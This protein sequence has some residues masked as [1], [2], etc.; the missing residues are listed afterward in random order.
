MLVAPFVGSIVDNINSVQVDSV[1]VDFQVREVLGS[2]YLG[3]KFYL[4]RCKYEIGDTGA[5]FSKSIG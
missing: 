3:R 2:T 4:L 1:S 5:E